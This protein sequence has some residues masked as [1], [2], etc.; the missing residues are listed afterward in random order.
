MGVRIRDSLQIHSLSMGESQGS[1]SLINSN[2]NGRIQ[3]I[4]VYP[5]SPA[6]GGIAINTKDYLS[7]GEGQFL[8]D[9]IIDFYLKYL[10]LEV[11]SESDQ[12]RTHV[13]NLNFHQ[14]LTNHPAVEKWT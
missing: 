3:T 5:P 6:K 12:H 4:T 11:L 13:F 10:T 8:T 1:T 2:S 7:L 9:K 14:H